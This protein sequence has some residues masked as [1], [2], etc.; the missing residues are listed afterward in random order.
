MNDTISVKLDGLS[1]TPLSSVFESKV[2]GKKIN[3]FCGE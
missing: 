2:F 1:D 3:I